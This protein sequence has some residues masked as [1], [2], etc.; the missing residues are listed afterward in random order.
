MSNLTTTL[1]QSTQ[2]VVFTSILPPQKEDN[3]CKKKENH[4]EKIHETI[5][6]NL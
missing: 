2:H 4:Q 1:T 6:E 5:D 3:L